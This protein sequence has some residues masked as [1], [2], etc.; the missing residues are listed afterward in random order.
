VSLAKKPSTALSQD[1]EVGVKWNVQR[2]CR[3]SHL[4]GIMTPQG[5]LKVPRAFGVLVGH[6]SS[7]IL[8]LP[9]FSRCEL[10]RPR[11]QKGMRAGVNR[12]IL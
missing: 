6:L 3:A 1:A 10:G 9:A 2:R 4:R 8:S 7:A 12:R 5:A 11:V